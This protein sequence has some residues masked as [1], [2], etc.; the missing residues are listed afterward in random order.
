ME[1]FNLFSARSSDAE[2]EESIEVSATAPIPIPCSA[3]LGDED[4]AREIQIA[5]AENEIIDALMEDFTKGFNP[6]TFHQEVMAILP[7]LSKD[8]LPGSYEHLLVI[9]LESNDRMQEIQYQLQIWLRDRYQCW[10]FTHP[11]LVSIADETYFVSE[12]EI[13]RKL[14]A[15]FRGE[16][17]SH[18]YWINNRR[19]VYKKVREELEAAVRVIELFKKDLYLE[20]RTVD[21]TKTFYTTLLVGQQRTS[22][23]SVKHRRLD[24]CK[25]SMTW[26]GYA[27]SD[28]EL[29]VF[30]QYYKNYLSASEPEK[31]RE[32]SMLPPSDLIAP[33]AS[34]EKAVPGDLAHWPY[35]DKNGLIHLLIK[36]ALWLSVGRG[37]S[38]VHLFCDIVR[39]FTIDGPP[40]DAKDD[41]ISY[42]EFLTQIRVS[43]GSIKSELPTPIPYRDRQQSENNPDYFSDVWHSNK[44]L[45]VV[46]VEN[47]TFFKQPVPKLELFEPPIRRTFRKEMRALKDT[48]EI[49]G[50][51]VHG[52]PHGEVRP[53]ER[54]I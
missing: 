51:L 15:P 2:D 48:V 39:Y 3:Y 28:M 40:E 36:M 32:L 35:E 20:L 8:V 47:P 34:S 45:G 16:G 7:I 38:A 53:N 33:V 19:K 12:L 50:S 44:S 5:E 30:H 22:I 42:L 25:A 37:L 13:L 6:S 46:L 52:C 11:D 9:L 14:L 54:H 49:T 41:L 18:I 24:A 29:T 17:E 27:E 31:A 4:D 1:I 26:D 23:M 43:D 10:A 21:E